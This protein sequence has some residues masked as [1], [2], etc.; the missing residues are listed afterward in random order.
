[1]QELK[2]PNCGHVF[3]V[4]SEIFESLAAQVRTAAFAEELSRREA[5]LTEQMKARADIERREAAQAMKRESD[6]HALELARRDAEIERLEA[7]AR[8]ASERAREQ[9]AARLA[10]AEAR[11]Q[12][13]LGEARQRLS[14]L[15]SEI[16][17]AE[18]ERKLAVMQER[19]AAAESVRDKERELAD[20][21]NR[22]QVASKEAELREAS[23]REQHAAALKEKDAQIEFYRDLKARMSTKMI[24]ESLETHCWTEFNRVRPYAFPNA[25]FDKDNDASSGTKGDFIFR[26]YADG[27]EYISIMFEMKNEADTTATRHRNSDFFAKLHKD[28]VQKKCEYAV[29]VS[30]LEP[31]NELY[32]DGIV[33][34]SHEYDKMFVVRPQFFLPI[35]SLLSRASRKTV[36]YRHELEKARRQSIDVSKFE[37]QLTAFRDGFARNYRLASERFQKAIVEIDNSIAHLQKIKEALLASENNLRLANNKADALTIRKL[38]R[39]NP[40]MRAKFDEA[41]AAASAVTPEPSDS[42]E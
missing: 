16:A 35:I 1:M 8:D 4:D 23:L 40:T 2:C 5:Q 17:R 30:L 32:N 20:L 3:T 13:E 11:H 29:L 10:E 22:A 27:M 31:D 19:S 39:G 33:D 38:T 26:D 37:D 9:T 41:R 15:Q 24:G 36:E 25:Y 21:R 7:G 18:S 34:M 12:R 6:A 28:R 14:D 42:P